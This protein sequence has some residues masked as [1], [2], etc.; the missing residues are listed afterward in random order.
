MKFRSVAAVIMLGTVLF[1]AA[2]SE[3]GLPRGSARSAG[4]SPERLAL[5]P[6]I[7]REAIARKEFPGAVLLVARKGRIVLHEAY[8]ESR[9]VPDHRPMTT[10]MIFDLASI[11]KP[12]ATAPAVLLLVERGR[13]S[14]WDKVKTYIPGFVAFRDWLGVEG[15][16]ARIWH[17]L[18]HTAGLPSYTDAEA[19]AKVLGRP[20]APEALVNYIAALPK[21][22]PPG[23]QF[24]YS[25]LGY[26]T[27][28]EIVRRVS[29]QSLDRFAEENIYRPLGMDRTLFRP[30]P[31]VLDLCV[32]TQVV[33]GRPL[34]GVVHDPLARLQGGISGN[35][36][37]FSTAGDLAVFAQMLLDGG[38]FRGKRIFS[39]AAVARMTS[40]Y[41]KAEFT[42]RGLG[43]DLH[44]AFAS[45]GGDLFGTHSFG[46]SG[47]T[48]TS[49]WIDPDT[50]TIVILLTNS[51]HPDDTGKILP[52]RSRVA[53]VVAGA[54][55]D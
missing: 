39:R 29:G 30:G 2:C 54:I 13:I 27:L 28:A 10:D 49:I 38:E 3:Q 46:H 53:N 55:R 48:G 18:T 12:L 25:C 23:Q 51:V 14:L 31:E 6:A 11:T 5:A 37:L 15:E 22:S 17:L 34:Q 35:A 47:Y 26:I 16:D 42:G 45:N 52:L 7:I 40:V 33:D 21:I 9:W 24:T 20:C 1:G 43:W 32:P 41:P 19:A 8:G 50:R 4:F 36:G 44:S